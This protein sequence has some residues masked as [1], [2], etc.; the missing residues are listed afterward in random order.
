MVIYED[1]F[2]EFNKQRV[3]YIVV[4]GM[5]FNLLGGSRSTLDLDVIVDMKRNNFIKII[6]ILKDLRYKLRQPID[7]I[8]VIDN[9]ARRELIKNKGMKALSFYRKSTSYEEID[10]IIDHPLNF[11]QAKKKIKNIKIEKL[12]LPVVSSKDLIKMKEVA[13]RVKD[14]ED[15]KQ[16]KFIEGL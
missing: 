5:A 2:R 4:G 7:P 16:L 1:I 6:N 9:K 11:S 15:I 13:R 8:I 12:T 14:K 3:K 10:I